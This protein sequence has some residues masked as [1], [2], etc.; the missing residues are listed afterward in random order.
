MQRN[1]NKNYSFL[2]TKVSPALLFGLAFLLLFISC[3]VKKL[4]LRNFSSN[5]SSVARSNE[6]NINKSSKA[7]AVM[8]ENCSFAKK[9]FFTAGLAYHVNIQPPVYFLNS[10]N[11]AGFKINYFLNGL[12][13]NYHP[14]TTH[15]NLSVPL[16]LQ[17]LR[18]LI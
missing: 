15:K 7:N 11:A 16:F 5:T 18:L 2:K 9:P 14:L 12:N 6:T 13:G 10:S 8:N 1:S 3:P 17:H 4:L